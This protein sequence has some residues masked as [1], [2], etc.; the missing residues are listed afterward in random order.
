M[1]T[2]QLKI[3]KNKK[4]PVQYFW[5]I[6]FVEEPPL[7]LLQGGRK[8]AFV[9]KRACIDTLLLRYLGDFHL[10]AAFLVT[11]QQTKAIAMKFEPRRPSTPT[12]RVLFTLRR[13]SSPGIDFSI[14]V[15]H[16]TARVLFTLRRWSS[17]SNDFCIYV[18]NRKHGGPVQLLCDVMPWLPGS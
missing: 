9:E 2:E 8:T 6:F 16:P 1:R 3:L 13:W 4:P 7:Y 12:A 10:I 11:A 5:I 14:Y 15:V 18:V 17:P